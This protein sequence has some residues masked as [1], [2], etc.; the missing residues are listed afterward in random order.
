MKSDCLNCWKYV[1]FFFNFLFFLGGACII[2]LGIYAL[3]QT[4]VQLPPGVQLKYVV[5]SFIFVGSILLVAG[6]FG[7]CGAIR[8]SKCM[9]MTYG[10]IL[11]VIFLIQ[12]AI[13]VV[14]YIFIPK[15]DAAIIEVL[16]SGN[17]KDYEALEKNAKCCG[18]YGPKD[19]TGDIPGACYADEANK[20]GLYDRGCKEFVFTYFYYIGGVGIAILLLEVFGMISACCLYKGTDSG[21]EA[22]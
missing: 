16:N 5:G 3:L 11:L 12:I 9:L 13:V 10:I 15:V 7:C 14:Y 4:T 22:A 18:W 21:Y 19:Y 2:G 8:E 6:F 1:V 17:A 20:T